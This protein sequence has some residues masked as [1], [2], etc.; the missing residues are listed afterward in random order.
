M[1]R[2]TAQFKATPADPEAKI[3][4]EA[5][6]SGNC[7]QALK[8]LKLLALLPSRKPDKT[9]YRRVKFKILQHPRKN[10]RKSYLLQKPHPYLAF[11]LLALVVS[12]TVA[13]MVDITLLE[14]MVSQSIFHRTSIVALF[15]ELPE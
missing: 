11:I 10:R 1:R 3:N 4:F 7:P 8:A 15:I 2:E 5:H 6:G 9:F 13:F 12:V 14:P